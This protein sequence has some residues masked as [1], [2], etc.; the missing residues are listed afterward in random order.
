[1]VEGCSLA[2]SLIRG[3]PEQLLDRYG[4]SARDIVDKV[5]KLVSY[6]GPVTE[7]S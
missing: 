2:A 4:I 3:K 5:R 1:M 6:A 7:L